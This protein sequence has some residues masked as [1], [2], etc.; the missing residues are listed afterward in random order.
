MEQ[1][2]AH[3]PEEVFLAVFQKA[4]GTVSLRMDDV[5]AGAIF[6][7]CRRKGIH[8][9][10]AATRVQDRDVLYALKLSPE[11]IAS[12]GILSGLGNTLSKILFSSVILDYEN[13]L[14]QISDEDFATGYSRFVDS[15]LQMVSLFV[16]RQ[17]NVDYIQP[18][19]VTKIIEFFMKKAGVKSIYNPYAGLC[20]YPIAMGANCDF[21]A[22]EFNEM[23]L[24]LAKIRLHSYGLDPAKIE[25]GNSITNWKAN[26]S[27]YDAI[28]AS[29]P[30]G[31]MIPREGRQRQNRLPNV[32]ED[33]FFYRAMGKDDTSDNHTYPNKLVS[34]IVPMAFTSR[35]ASFRL[36]EQMCK[37][38][39]LEYVISLPEGIFAHTSIRTSI[40]ILSPSEKHDSVKFVDATSFIN[41]DELKRRRLDW[42]RVI[43]I[44]EK[45]DV[46]FIKTVSYEELSQQEYIL[47]GDCYLPS[48]TKCDDEHFIAHLSD[49]LERIPDSRITSS[50]FE[51]QVPVEAFSRS[52][53]NILHPR[54]DLITKGFIDSGYSVSEPCILFL[55][56]ERQVLAYLHKSNTAIAV[57]RRT[58]AFRVKSN[59]VS[60]EY[61]TLFLLRDPVF[62]QNIIDSTAWVTGGAARHMLL[63]SVVLMKPE[64]QIKR[65][66][67]EEKKE[68]AELAMLHAAEESL[69]GIRKAGS[70]IAHILATPFQRQNRII[71]S[72][73]TLEPGSD[74]YVRRVTSL[75]DVCQY[76]RRMTIA[77]GGDLRTATFHPQDI[78]ISHEVADYVRAWGNFDNSDDY[79]V[80]IQDETKGD[81]HLNADPIMLWIAFDTLLEN[82]YRHGFRDGNYTVPEGNL[83]SMRITPVLIEDKPFVQI[84]VMNNG[85]KAPDGYTIEDFKTRG[86]F[87]GDSGHTGLGG[88]HVY[89]IAHRLGGFIAYRTEM[90]WPFIIDILLPVE[91]D[92]STKFNT[93][94]EE[95]FV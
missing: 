70:D 18:I 57:N 86:N 38:G 56:K 27:S 68:S 85:L 31:M 83:V 93:R 54:T 45:G 64:D 7:Y 20:S 34:T 67:S 13:V 33:L 10:A 50:V 89:T 44:I 71:R 91:G 24:A 94:Y 72:L 87:V 6:L 90:N 1:Y 8:C 65:L 41:D 73:S 48:S 32:V 76:I 35:P 37:D 42:E 75:I 66:Q 47:N 2:V 12:D 82:A 46:R 61:I 22:Q 43:S 4:K 88:N 60:P 28:V 17:E 74:K 15:F 16:G 55:V 63:R 40:I 79:K 9:D 69:Y 62:C 23:T 92:C 26:A 29:V 53:L 59:Q 3:S 80:I 95:T 25:Q 30:F 84:S 78:A 77:I 21:Y 5:L 51:R 81:I 19:S 11:V 49:I 39:T 36:R 58:F 14:W 52:V